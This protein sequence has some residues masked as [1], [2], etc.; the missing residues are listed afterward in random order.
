M[1]AKTTPQFNMLFQYEYEQ[2]PILAGINSIGNM[3]AL[4]P[5]V[6]NLG[7]DWAGHL[8][9]IKNDPKLNQLWSMVP[10]VGSDGK[11][12]EMVCMNHQNFN[13]WLWGMNIKSENFKNDLWESYKKG[14][15]IYILTM[16]KISLDKV[17]EL[18]V[19]SGYVK[20][21]RDTQK[22][23]DELDTKIA[24]KSS[25][26]TELKRERKNLDEKLKYLLR[27]NPNQLKLEI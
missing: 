11:I 21:I 8:R 10:A 3:I 27:N 7:L 26:L 6:E 4:K 20:E 22:Q 5:I 14:L 24:E 9:V 12:R 23:I 16:L 15:V 2:T 17:Q 18:Q 19:E 13:D 1:S 25:D